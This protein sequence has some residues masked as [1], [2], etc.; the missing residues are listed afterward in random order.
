MMR[1]SG[2]WFLRFQAKWDGTRLPIGSF[3]LTVFVV[4]FDPLNFWKLGQVGKNQVADGI[5]GAA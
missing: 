3:R 2:I 4:D 5:G 1:L